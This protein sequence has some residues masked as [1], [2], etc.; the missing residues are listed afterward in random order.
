MRVIIDTSVLVPALMFP[1][2][3][4]WIR[5]AWR[6]ETIVPLISSDTIGELKDVLAYAQFG[7]TAEQQGLLLDTYLPWTE[8][9]MVPESL[10]V[11]DCRDPNDVPFLKLAIAGGADALITSDPDL[12]ILSSEFSVPIITPRELNERF[13]TVVT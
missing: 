7:L 3:F 13:L 5:Q 9:I 1:G 10:T 2:G 11:P 12:L 8:T 6:L 4:S